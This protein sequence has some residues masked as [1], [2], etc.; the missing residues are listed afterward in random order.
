[1]GKIIVFVLNDHSFLVQYKIVSLL[2]HEVYNRMCLYN[3]SDLVGPINHRNQEKYHEEIAT[4][5]GEALN[6]LASEVRVQ[7]HVENA[8]Q[9]N[10]Q[11]EERD[12][13]VQM[14]LPKSLSHELFAPFLQFFVWRFF[15]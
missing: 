15:A 7:L 1:M 14:F 9:E 6:G 4:E 12:Y 13:A 3:F 11:K 5:Y 10:W 2:K 8:Q